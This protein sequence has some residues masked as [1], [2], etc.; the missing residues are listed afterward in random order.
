[1]TTR[2]FKSELLILVL[3]LFSQVIMGQ[4]ST[5]VM[6]L[7]STEERPDF[8]IYTLDHG[9]HP[10]ASLDD[11]T[12]S[13]FRLYVGLWK[14]GKVVVSSDRTGSPPYFLLSLTPTTGQQ[15]I[16]DAI[17]SASLIQS[18]QFPP[19]SSLARVQWYDSDVDRLFGPDVSMYEIKALEASSNANVPQPAQDI[20]AL[21]NRLF[22]L[23][24]AANT[25]TQLNVVW[26]P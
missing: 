7:G 15:V 5:T 21:K 11:K 20:F 24:P 1:M 2:R 19:S 6:H 9:M 12:T 17:S 13:P 18:G 8:A 23:L 26:E 16:T 4:T 3:F 10:L 14:T 22:D 25:G